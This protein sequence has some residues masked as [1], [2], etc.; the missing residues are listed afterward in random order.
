VPLYENVSIAVYRVVVANSQTGRQCI[1]ARRTSGS[2]LQRE[3]G[4]G[5]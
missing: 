4:N 3:L 2:L 1:A 5:L